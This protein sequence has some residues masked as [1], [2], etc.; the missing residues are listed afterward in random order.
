MFSHKVAKRVFIASDF[1]TSSQDVCSRRVVALLRL[2]LQLFF[3]RICFQ[4][5]QR[6]G[7]KKRAVKLVQTINISAEKRCNVLLQL[8][9]HIKIW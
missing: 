4:L 1:E 2:Q 8:S 5:A 9:G 7:G 6:G 3:E